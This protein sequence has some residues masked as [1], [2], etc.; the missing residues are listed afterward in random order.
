MTASVTPVADDELRIV[1]FVSTYV[2]L[3][4]VDASP[5]VGLDKLDLTLVSTPSE[6]MR[7]TRAAAIKAAY[8]N[9]RT[10]FGIGRRQKTEGADTLRRR[11]LTG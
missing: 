11:S 8:E 6:T 1:T 7:V 3:F 10:I 2:T 9:L 4:A 5:F